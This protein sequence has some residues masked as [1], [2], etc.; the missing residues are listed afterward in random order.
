MIFEGR[1][2]KSCSTEGGGLSNGGLAASRVEGKGGRSA[3]GGYDDREAELHLD[4]SVIDNN[5]Q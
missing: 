5:K 2:G 3:E 1:L 4:R